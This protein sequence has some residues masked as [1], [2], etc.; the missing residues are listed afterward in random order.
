MQQP[1]Q[2]LGSNVKGENDN[3]DSND[4]GNDNEIAVMS[5]FAEYSEAR[6]RKTTISPAIAPPEKSSSPDGVIRK[7]PFQN[8]LSSE[9]CFSSSRRE[10]PVAAA[11]KQP[12][13]RLRRTRMR[14]SRGG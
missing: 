5:T 4:N 10:G 13:C 14:R 3:D 2:L 9:S 1:I 12:S 6:N 8:M 11:A 7:R